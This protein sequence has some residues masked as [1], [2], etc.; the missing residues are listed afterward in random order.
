MKYLLILFFLTS[1]F[2]AQE[3]T[4]TASS[5]QQANDAP[6][7]EEGPVLGEMPE[8]LVNSVL[9]IQAGSQ[10][11][12][13]ENTVGELFL[14]KTFNEKN[15]P[16][17]AV[18]T[19]QYKPGEISENQYVLNIEMR[20]N[21]R[22]HTKILYTFKYDNNGNAYLVRWDEVN[23]VGRQVVRRDSFLELIRGV[24]YFQSLQQPKPKA[25]VAPPPPPLSELDLQTNQ[26]A[27]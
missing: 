9:I 5:E 13:Y 20:S 23:F 3:T 10:K 15:M 26:Q 7:V 22:L 1:T 24:D 11:K 27:Q 17:N 2:F 8:A 18:R 19:F 25:S 14:G 4:N 21:G 12:K 16:D 6:A